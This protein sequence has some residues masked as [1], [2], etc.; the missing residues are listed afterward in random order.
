MTPTVILGCIGGLIYGSF[1][2]VL[3]WRLPEGK[4]I[5]GR[6]MCR[7]CGRTLV[8][9][10]LIPV[11]SYVI[12]SG[13]C[14]SCKAPIHAR[15]PAVELTVAVVLGLFFAIR[16]PNLEISAVMS[17]VALL[18]LTTLFFFDFFYFILP[19]VFIF[20]AIAIYGAYDVFILK[21]P[22]LF[23]VAAFL[24]AGFFGILY[25]VSRGKKLGFGDVKLAFLLGLIFGYPL[26]LLTI[27]L[28]VWLAT[29][30]AVLLL[31]SKKAKLHDPIPLGSFL[32]LA[33]I[34]CI[35]F[36]HETLLPTFLF[37]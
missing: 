34:L 13:T 17:V 24:G 35:I 6:S 28:G 27:I 30:V 20:P 32:V 19:D 22:M 11:I 7:S 12:L 4:G 26:G 5:G 23:F 37:R 9:H 2:N 18:V 33:A 25:A 36:Y 3:L 8:W 29:G 31:I 21:N 15:Y 10:D 1:L 16:T 14:R